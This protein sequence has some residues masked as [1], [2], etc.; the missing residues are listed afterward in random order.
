[1]SLSVSESFREVETLVGK[2]LGS[3]KEELLVLSLIQF[4]KSNSCET[5]NLRTQG[6]NNSPLVKRWLG[7]IGSVGLIS[8]L[9]RSTSSFLGSVSVIINEFNESGDSSISSQ[10]GDGSTL[11]F[12]ILFELSE[13]DSFS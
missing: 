9:T 12:L 3:I 7:S 6:S 11:L 1:M 10:V 4:L 5:K 2:N 13:V 8:S